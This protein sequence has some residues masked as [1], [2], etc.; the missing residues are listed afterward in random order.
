MDI[1]REGSQGQNQRC[2]VSKK[3]KKKEEEEEKEEDKKKKR[4]NHVNYK[5][6]REMLPHVYIFLRNYAYVSKHPLSKVKRNGVIT[7]LVVC[8]C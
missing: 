7:L 3:K 8:L 6:F 4:T 1:S 2:V 5:H